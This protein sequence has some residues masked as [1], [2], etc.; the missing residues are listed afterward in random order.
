MTTRDV[1]DG[2]PIRYEARDVGG[3]LVD[4]SV[5]LTVTTPAG[6]TTPSPTHTG[7]GLYDY[8]IPLT[9]SGVHHWQWDASGAVTDR[10]FGSVLAADPGTRTYA[11]LADLKAFL[12]IT[13]TRDDAQL[14]VRLVA[15]TRRVELDTG[16]RFW[17]ASAVATRTYRATHPEILLTDDIAT[18]T[19]LVVEVG[20]GSSW[21]ALDTSAMDAIPDNAEAK[22]RAIE[23]LRL[24]S[25]AWP[26]YGA[27]RVRITALWGWLA[28]P[29]DIETA[30]ILASARLYRRMSA[31]EGVL[32]NS[33]F[34]PVR[35]SRYDADYDNLIGPYVRSTP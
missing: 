15:G 1:G 9:T 6:V 5:S 19:G 8:V 21:S 18:S 31:V 3:T 17:P 35:V 23:G 14:S 2:Y 24:T 28:V 33:E 13:D 30:C 22:G 12:K 29:E 11:T 4:A 27:T 25:G 34:G 26:L 7:T 32:G 10:A 16:R 20:R